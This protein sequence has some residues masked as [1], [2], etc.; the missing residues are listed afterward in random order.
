MME[1]PAVRWY[2]SIKERSSRRQF[3][4]KIIEKPKLKKLRNLIEMINQE[5]EGLRI[6]LVQNDV[7]EIFTGILGSYG[8]ISGAPA[9]LAFVGIK[10]IPYLEEK[11]GYG[12]EAVILEATALE[13]GT[14]WV[15]GTFKAEEVLAD[16]DLKKSEKLYAISPLGYPEDRPTI[17]E[18]ILKTVISSK[19]RLDLDKLI[20]N[21]NDLEAEL[22][23]IKT[24]LKAARLAPSAVNRQPWRFKIGE[25]EIIIEL[26]SQEK[27]EEREK[28][29]DC[30]IA[31]LHLEVGALK[32][33]V[34]G[35]WEYLKGK[36]VA[37][38]LVE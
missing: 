29:L 15:S 33:G 1:I 30:G 24:A 14:C 22:E 3:Y 2:Q 25:N 35:S 11:I 23:W 38:F 10:D 32:A 19:K 5:I 4:S 21:K 28:N 18:R 34:S 6:I 7:E 13:L 31:M 27:N 17:S 36:E 37:R 8:K 20:I 16:L 26:D 9:Y 12:G